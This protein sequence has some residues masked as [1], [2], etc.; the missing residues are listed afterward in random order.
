MCVDGLDMR[1]IDKQVFNII[2]S[3]I[4]CLGTIEIWLSLIFL[5]L[6][7]YCENMYKYEDINKLAYD[8]ITKMS[9]S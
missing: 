5:N 9:L 7:R 3:Q 6:F 8:S 4:L 1:R 2:S